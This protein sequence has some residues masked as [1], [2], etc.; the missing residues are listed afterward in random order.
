MNRC[1]DVYLIICAIKNTVNILL[2]YTVH[3]LRHTVKKCP[4]RIKDTP[5]VLFYC[6]PCIYTVYFKRLTARLLKNHG[7]HYSAFFIYSA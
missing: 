7:F 5:A 2:K 4:Q 6:I 1:S 3:L